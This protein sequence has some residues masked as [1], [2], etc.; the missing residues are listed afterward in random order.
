MSH[1]VLIFTFPVYNICCYIICHRTEYVYLPLDF[2]G[3]SSCNNC[4]FVCMSASR[5]F[6]ECNKISTPQGQGDCGQSRFRQVRP[7]G[8]HRRAQEE[9]TFIEM[10]GGMAETD[11]L[12]WQQERRKT[13]TWSPVKLDRNRN[14]KHWLYCTM[15]IKTL[16]F[17]TG[18]TAHAR[19]FYDT[20]A[21]SVP[22]CFVHITW[23]FDLP[24]QNDLSGLGGLCFA[25]VWDHVQYLGFDRSIS[26]IANTCC[27][28]V[29]T[30]L[31]CCIFR[32]SATLEKTGGLCSASENAGLHTTCTTLQLLNL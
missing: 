9:Q 20:L 25:A 2:F 5:W 15:L 29:I 26:R 17:F 28:C 6:Q 4:I 18:K 32:E 3:C 8:G 13:Y 19:G 16:L 11:A 31:S 14:Q 24:I 21:E 10:N 12:T 7:F 30:V 1:K 23:H 22:V 27:A